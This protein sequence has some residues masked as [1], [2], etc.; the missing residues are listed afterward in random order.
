MFISFGMPP[1]VQ[2]ICD[3]LLEAEDSASDNFILVHAQQDFSFVVLNIIAEKIF[4][5]SQWR[6]SFSDF[7]ISFDGSIDFRQLRERGCLLRR[8]AT[9]FGFIHLVFPS[10]R[11]LIPD[12]P[13]ALQRIAYIDPFS[14]S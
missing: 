9:T 14:G 11:E 3:L 7:P 10:G 1:V 12:F 5:I 4:E 6:N 2:A 13:F 8:H